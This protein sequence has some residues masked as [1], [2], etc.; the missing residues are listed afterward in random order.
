M[1]DKEN[2]LDVIHFYII[3]IRICVQNGYSSILCIRTPM[4]QYNE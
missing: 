1:C 4:V 3:N 2:S